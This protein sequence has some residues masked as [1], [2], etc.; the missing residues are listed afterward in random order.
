MPTGTPHYGHIPPYETIR[1]DSFTTPRDVDGYKP[2][3][4]LLLTH[5]HSDHIGGLAHRSFGQQVIC[6]P[7]AKEMLLLFEDVKSRIEKDNGHKE[8]ITRRYS[9]L[10]GKIMRSSSGM[11]HCIERDLLVCIV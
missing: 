7:D 10:K 8:L 2:A 11:G 5:T 3:S 1:V 6:S 9:H 4:L